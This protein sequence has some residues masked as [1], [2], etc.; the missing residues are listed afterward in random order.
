MVV[1]LAASRPADQAMPATQLAGAIAARCMVRR[2]LG[3][4]PVAHWFASQPICAGSQGPETEWDASGDSIVMARSL[5]VVAV[6]TALSLLVAAALIVLAAWY[7]DAT[8]GP[9]AVVDDH[10]ACRR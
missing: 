8:F 1:V 9:A 3:V 7:H 2:S 6:A 5:A 4:W 10:D